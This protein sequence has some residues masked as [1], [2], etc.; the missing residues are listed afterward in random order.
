MIKTIIS[1][2]NFIKS[3]DYLALLNNK[4][5]KFVNKSFK[6][7]VVL[8]DDAYLARYINT[9]ETEVSNISQATHIVYNIFDWATG[10]QIYRFLL[11]ENVEIYLLDDNPNDFGTK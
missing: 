5:V 9:K 7:P 4:R 3:K 8:F 10:R 11:E 6:S 1:S 2:D